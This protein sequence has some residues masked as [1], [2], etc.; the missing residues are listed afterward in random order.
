MSTIRATVSGYYGFGNVGD[1]AVLEGMLKSFGLAGCEID[2]KVLT[3]SVHRTGLLH[4]NVRPVAR[5]SFSGLFSAIRDCDVFISGGGS[6]F[7]D[8]TSAR[9]V[10][11][12]LYVLRMAQLL[13]K[14]T[15]IFA[16]GVGPLSRPYLKNAVGK[17]MGLADVLA[18][19]DEDSRAFIESI[20]VKK[21]VTVCTDPA[22]L[23]GPD[24][25]AAQKSF[26]SHKIDERPKIALCL[27]PWE[28]ASDFIEATVPAIES[29]CNK[30]G[31]QI[32][33][34]PMLEREDR[35][36]MEQ[37]STGTML[38][39]ISIP[40]HAMGIIGSCDMVVGMRL[41][42]LI[43][44][45]SCGVPFVSLSYDPKVE[46]FA[47]KTGCEYMLALDTATP[48]EVGQ[49][50]LSLWE[51]R[52]TERERLASVREGLSEDALVP[53]RMIGGM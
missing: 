43:F 18:V 26:D 31:A 37:I 34:L 10:I 23:V 35:P 50:I 8:A 51:K 5:Y 28:H 15:A 20:G 33:L 14:K 22:V 16:Q 25:E 38:P 32:V 44:A 46:S 53:A 4:K 6:L 17:A 27:R 19:R 7:Q 48:E 13:G 21:S 52:K 41:H 2:A 45:A 39:D 29:A 47:R 24:M 12:Y 30:T 40:G 49:V 9:S 1:E 3:G 11:Y 42:S 36:L